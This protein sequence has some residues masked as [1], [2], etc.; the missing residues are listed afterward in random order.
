MIGKHCI[1]TFCKGQS[2]IALSSGEAELYAA[3]LACSMAI[4]MQQLYRDLGVEVKIAVLMDADAGI[5]MMRRQGLGTA[6]H[7]ATQYFWVQERVQN[8]DI[9]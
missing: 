4:G 9:E 6:K 8:K 3:V 5:A 2:V 1:V 7:V